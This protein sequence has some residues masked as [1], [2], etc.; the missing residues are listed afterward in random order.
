MSFDC[1]KQ[2]RKTHV[3]IFSSFAEENLAEHRQ[4]A[5]KTSRQCWVE[6]AAL[7][8]R[9]WGKGWW[10]TPLKKTARVEATNW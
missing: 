6:F 4:A 8:E 3:R 5:K 2:N 7:Q 10:N 1:C 9:M